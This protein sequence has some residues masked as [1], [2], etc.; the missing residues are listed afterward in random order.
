MRLRASVID[1]QAAQGRDR[2]ED[3]RETAVKSDV[4]IKARFTLPRDPHERVERPRRGE[5]RHSR[6]IYTVVP[7]GDG[8]GDARC[9][10]VTRQRRSES[11]NTGIKKGGEERDSERGWM[12][13]RVARRGE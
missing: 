1:T 10:R 8:N 4:K 3:P 9:E 5:R 6:G 12:E 11:E 2:F 7:S 13:E